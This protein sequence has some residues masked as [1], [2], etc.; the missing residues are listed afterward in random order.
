MHERNLLILFVA[1]TTLAILI[2]LGILVGVFFVS[3]K[4]SDQANRGMDLSHNLVGP[5]HKAAETLETV[6][7]SI[8]HLSS[9]TH[10]QLR[11]LENWWHRAA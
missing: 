1:L 10:E 8:A 11:N 9:S 4:L 5:L 7:A 3:K 6:S 2:Q